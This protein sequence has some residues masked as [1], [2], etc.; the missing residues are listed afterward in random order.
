MGHSW[1]GSDGAPSCRKYHELCMLELHLV[2]GSPQPWE[3]LDV[4]LDPSL[5]LSKKSLF[6]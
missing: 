2:D 4:F 6:S 1:Q 3:S 5:L